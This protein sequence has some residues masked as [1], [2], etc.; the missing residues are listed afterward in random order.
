VV[1]TDHRHSVI[2]RCR[3]KQVRAFTVH[4]EPKLPSRPEF[5]VEAAVAKERCK[6]AA[7]LLFDVQPAPR[8][9]GWAAAIYGCNGI[10]RLVYEEEDQCGNCFNHSLASHLPRMSAMGG[11]RTP[12]RRYCSG[13]LRQSIS[14]NA[15]CASASVMKIRTATG[16]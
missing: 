15:A 10:A 13:W 8:D 2:W 4:N 16:A 9:S 1:S 12:D 3:N 14:R 7:P 5:D 6:P 11:K